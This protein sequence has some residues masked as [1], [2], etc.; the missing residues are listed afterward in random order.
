MARRRN[1]RVLELMQGEA[2]LARA[3]GELEIG[4]AR[5]TDAVAQA[6]AVSD[7]WREYQ[8]LV[9]FAIVKLEQEDSR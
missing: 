6:R 7:H 5:L 1:L 2:L 8:C 4:C 3:D 9:W